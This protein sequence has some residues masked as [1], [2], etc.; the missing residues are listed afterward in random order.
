M[1]H[2]SS[3]N[4]RALLTSPRHPNPR[5]IVALVLKS[6]CRKAWSPTSITTT[7]SDDHEPSWHARF[8]SREVQSLSLDF[9]PAIK[10]KGSLLRPLLLLN[11]HK[12]RYRYPESSNEVRQV[13]CGF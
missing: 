3:D 1:L 2:Q 7:R 8:V 4:R 6:I 5:R 10:Q 13:A 12:E 9:L 11:N